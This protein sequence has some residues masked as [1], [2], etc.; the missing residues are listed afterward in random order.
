MSNNTNFTLPAI[1]YEHVIIASMNRTRFVRD[2]NRETNRLVWGLLAAFLVAILITAY[3]TFVFVRSIIVSRG[4]EIK[5]TP[6]VQEASDP[7][8]VPLDPHAIDVPLQTSGPPGRAWDGKSRL[9]VLVLGLDHRDWEEDQ[10]PARTDTMILLTMD[11]ET[12]SAGML[13]IPRDLWVP[14]PGYDH[15]KIN[16]AY[17]L[18]EA[19]GLEGG[20][21]G[22]A[23]ETVEQFLDI[24]VN[25]YAQIDFTA[26][27]QFIDELGG[28]EV[29]VPEAI[30]IDPIGP[31]N[32]V[33]LS[34]GIQML[35]GPVALAYARSRNSAGNDIDRAFR[36]QQVI[37]AIRD[38]ILSLDMLPR[39]IE[40]SPILYRQ[41]ARGVHTNMN[42]QE[43]ISVA[44]IASQIDRTAIKQGSIGFEEA[45]QQY[46]WDGQDILLPDPVAVRLLRDEIFSTEG[47]VLQPAAPTEVSV[48][49]VELRQTEAAQ[50]MVYNGTQTVGLAART[51]EYL[52][53]N[54]INVVSAE[55]AQEMYDF[56]TVIDYTGKI[57][58]QQYLVDL[59]NIQPSQVFS[60]FDPN[61]RVDIAVYLGSDWALSN[62]LP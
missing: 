62:N 56:T 1:P 2:P 28:I 31:N 22:L 51:R 14:I 48:N 20:G 8:V 25:Y 15:A 19:Y 40:K 23:I 57:Y 37:M 53:S 52:V 13:S 38:R 50:V 59:L 11:P 3:L 7:A 49:P 54:Q 55:N 41:I 5:P 10:G 9:T 21:P 42:L 12:R 6:I 36:Q 34:P 30:T 4:A 18:G 27:E 17:F 47:P 24:P 46:S 16:T 61:S 44:W 45:T 26:F 29:N 32:T 58:T 43:I 35:D 33:H 39:L 60:S